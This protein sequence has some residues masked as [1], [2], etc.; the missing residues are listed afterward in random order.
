MAEATRRFDVWLAALDPAPGHEIQKTRPVVVLSP[1]EMN[2][3][4]KT[5]VAAPL[6][7]VRRA[8]PFRPDTELDGVAGQLA[9]DQ[10]RAMDRTY[11]QRR[12]GEIS[13]AEGEAAL[14]VLR[15]MFE[16]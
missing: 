1:D 9:L 11:L 13:P 4:L 2:R 16:V 12:L 8:W 3:H 6:T 15:E 7:S 14:A 5:V 10:I